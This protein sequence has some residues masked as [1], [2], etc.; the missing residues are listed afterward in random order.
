MRVT[1]SLVTSDQFLEDPFTPE[2]KSEAAQL[3]EN[4]DLVLDEIETSQKKLD[5]DFVKLGTMLA[6]VQTK[7]YWIEYGHKS[8]NSF[9]KTIEPKVNKGRSQLYAC[10]A[11]AQQL[12]PIMDEEDLIMTGISKASALA[13][14]VKKTGKA[15]D[16][17]IAK[18][19]DPKVTVDQFKEELGNH[20]G[21]RD[22]FEMGTWY[23]LEGVFFSPEE[24]AE[25][26]RAVSVA[27]K[28]DP[29]LKNLVTWRNASAPDRKDIL[30]RWIMT[31]LSTYEAES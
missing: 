10:A 5:T 13:S 22:E 12:L 29:P 31:F 6:E 25:F 21:G 27:C 19:K 1:E 18:A 16:E 23:P 4:L 28:T 2:Q 9:I 17:L 26:E 20:F 15:P 30:Q 7:K 11:I 8:Y 24:K 3:K 14:Q